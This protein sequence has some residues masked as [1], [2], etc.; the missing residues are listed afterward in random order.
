MYDARPNFFLEVLNPRLLIC[1]INRGHKWSIS[2]EKVRTSSIY[3]FFIIYEKQYA[4]ASYLT[5]AFVFQLNLSIFVFF[6]HILNTFYI[7]MPRLLNC[8]RF[9]NKVADSVPLPC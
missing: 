7:K 3:I 5:D 1:G 4:Q 8:R 6:Y 9:F 2:T